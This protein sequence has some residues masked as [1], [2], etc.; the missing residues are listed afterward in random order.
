MGAVEQIGDDGVERPW[1]ASRRVIAAR[2]SS[3]DTAGGYQGGLTDRVDVSEPTGVPK[4][5]DVYPRWDSNPR[6]RRE[7]AAS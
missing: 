1:A 4:I 6:Y 7:R 2:S 5:H 3:A